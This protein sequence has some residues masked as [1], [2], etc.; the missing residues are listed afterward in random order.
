[1]FNPKPTSPNLAKRTAGPNNRRQIFAPVCEKAAGV[2]AR[3]LLVFS[4]C[5]GNAWVCASRGGLLGRVSLVPSGHH[6]EPGGCARAEYRAC[7]FGHGGRERE[8]A[9]VEGLEFARREAE[10]LRRECG[11]VSARISR[12]TSPGCCWA[13]AGLRPPRFPAGLGL[14]DFP[15]L[16]GFPAMTLV[17]KNGMYPAILSLWVTFF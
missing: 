12:R 2:R 1:M 7:G 10:P 6:V 3:G 5:G 9:V 8:C 16:F 17:S 4:D 11:R 14:P 13:D 15:A